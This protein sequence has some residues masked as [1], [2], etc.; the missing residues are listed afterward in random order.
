[1]GGESG[2]LLPGFACR[3]R[4][5]A[6]KVGTSLRTCA[7]ALTDFAASLAS[8]E[9]ELAHARSVALTG[10]NA[11]TGTQIVRPDD[12]AG[13]AAPEIVEAHNRRVA[14][15]D[16]AFSIA[17]AARTSEGEAH[18]RLISALARATDGGILRFVAE[19]LGLLPSGS[20]GVDRASWG[21]GVG[22]TG[23]G[24]AA[25]YVRIAHYGIFAPRERMPN[26]RFQFVSFKESGRWQNA[27]RMRSDS[28]WRSQTG[29]T[30]IRA[31]WGTVGKV[32]GRAGS[33]L[34][35]GTAAY[36]QWSADADDPSMSTQESITRTGVKGGFTAG[37]AWAGAAGGAQLG[38]A[39]GSFGGPV[40]TV[41]GGAV[42]GLVGGF[43]GSEV[44]GAVGDALKEPFGDAADAVGDAVGGAAGDAAGAIGDAASDLGDKL[45]F[46]D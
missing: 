45:S 28:N 20:D 15:Y 17:E 12:M 5:D 35:F 36:D 9:A 2:G 27:W 44:G 19:G 1:M 7:S 8:V 40:G 38:A 34:T 39:I 37:G 24:W 32:A 4:G 41:V 22:L 21:A 18:S 23:A 25:N 29:R 10:G 26:G 33:V 43:V 42:G 11:I 6:E 30:E 46:W 13:P 16:E 14:A 31:K 3:R